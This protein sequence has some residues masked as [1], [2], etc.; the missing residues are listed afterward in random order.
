MS[1]LADIVQW[2]TLTSFKI[3]QILWCCM[4]LAVWGYSSCG[5]VQDMSLKNPRM[6]HPK[7]LEHSLHLST[8]K[9]RTGKTSDGLFW[10][11]SGSGFNPL[12]C[13]Q[14]VCRS[15]NLHSPSSSVNKLQISVNRCSLPTNVNN[16]AA[17]RS[18]NP[19]SPKTT[20]KNLTADQKKFQV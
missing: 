3:S 19:S 10:D 20:E 18:L 13:K 7:W 14:L 17:S 8:L 15:P 16:L 4:D 6:V 5:V 2:E 11:I 12:P 1:S 9:Q